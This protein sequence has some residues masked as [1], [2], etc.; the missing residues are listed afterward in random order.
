MQTAPKA[1]ETLGWRD[2]LLILRRRKWLA[3]VLLLAL[4]TPA[5][6]APQIATARGSW[7]WAKACITSASEAGISAAA[8]GI[9]LA[10][11]VQWKDGIVKRLTGGEGADIHVIRDDGTN[12]RNMPWGRDGNEFCQGHQCWRGRTTWAIMASTPWPN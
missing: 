10:K 2:C 4:A 7:S 3:L 6:A 12:F 9:D 11:T 8:P 1:R 5:P